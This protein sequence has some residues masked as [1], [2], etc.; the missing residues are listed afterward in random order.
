MKHQYFGDVNDYQ[1]YGILRA[2]A[3]EGLQI[4]VCWMLTENDARSD[5]K[6][7][8]YLNDPNRWR[9]YDPELYDALKEEVITRNRRDV[10]CV[11]ERN[12]IRH[13]SFVDAILDGTLATRSSWLVELRQKRTNKDLV[14]FDP[15]NGIEVPSIPKTRRNSR[16]YVYWEELE[17]TWRSGMSLL[18]YQ[19]F[20]REKRDPFI[21]RLGD[22]FRARFGS[23]EVYAIRTANVVFFIAPQQQ[24]ADFL[25][26]R[27]HNVA[28]RWQG[29]IQLQGV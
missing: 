29:Q 8:Q 9:A 1:K 10:A 28:V 27:A 19:H 17:E 13:A 11:L 5:G 4:L 23:T 6:L 25:V 12:L 3:K 24:H 2:L 15:D 26:Q 16:K 7:I 14:F 21:A 20:R 18:V 22:E